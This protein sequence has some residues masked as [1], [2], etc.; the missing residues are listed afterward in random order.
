V[1]SGSPQFWKSVHDAKGEYPGPV[2]TRSSE[3][4]KVQWHLTLICTPN[5]VS[6][7]IAAPSEYIMP[8][9]LPGAL[10]R[11]AD[12]SYRF[13]DEKPVASLWQIDPHRRAVFLKGKDAE[14]FMS[15]IA[16]NSRLVVHLNHRYRE[17]NIVGTSEAIVNMRHACHV[18]DVSRTFDSLLA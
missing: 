4:E 16:L 17:F 10:G 2:L 5:S 18:M 12:V 13:E 15:E 14:L 7:E 8:V 1:S 9:L 6:V 11:R 3:D